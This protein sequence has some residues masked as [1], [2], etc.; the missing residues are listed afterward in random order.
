[1]SLAGSK[2]SR[3]ARPWYRASLELQIQTMAVA[4][5]KMESEARKSYGLK[6]D[7]ALGTIGARREKASERVESLAASKCVVHSGLTL[8]Q[9]ATARLDGP[10]SKEAPAVAAQ[11]SRWLADRARVVQ[12]TANG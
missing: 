12:R 1:M 2:V 7:D 5:S 11:G 9:D 4:A 8:V 3:T 10:K 6:V